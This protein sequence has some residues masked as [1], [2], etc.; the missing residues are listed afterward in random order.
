MADQSIRATQVSASKTTAE[1][2]L[3]VALSYI[4]DAERPFFDK[5]ITLTFEDTTVLFDKLDKAAQY[6]AAARAKDPEQSLTIHDEKDGGITYTQDAIAGAIS[7][8]EGQIAL[9]AW[10]TAFNDQNKVDALRRARG[11]F[12]KATHFV[13]THAFYH[14]N[15]ADVCKLQ[16]D[17]KAAVDH[18]S[19]AL[20]LEP[21]SVERTENDTGWFRTD[22]SSYA[23]RACSHVRQP[24]RMVFVSNRRRCCLQRIQKRSFGAGCGLNDQ[25]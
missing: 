14:L 21:E 24:S 13:P 1:N 16:D 11:A 4:E 23:C 6:V 8:R 17:K 25:G 18:V 3:K 9:L 15:L 5:K 20:K 19:T 22:C 7:Y 10:R 2:D 12:T